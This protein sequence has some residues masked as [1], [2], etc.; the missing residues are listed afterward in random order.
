[1]LGIDNSQALL[2]LSLVFLSWV[3]HKV[4]AFQQVVRSIEYVLISTPEPGIGM[5][6]R[7]S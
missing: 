5:F 7:L 4:I 6:A 1:M 2:L 3:A